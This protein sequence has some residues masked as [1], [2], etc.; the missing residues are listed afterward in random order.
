L[1]VII[2]AIVLKTETGIQKYANVQVH[3]ELL[4]ELQRVAD[5]FGYR[6]RAEVVNDAVRRFID[7]KCSLE[8]KEH[9]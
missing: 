8:T 2:V 9:R 5:D 3:K 1:T 7:E 6:S 4:K